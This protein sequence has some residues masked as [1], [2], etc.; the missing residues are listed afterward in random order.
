MRGH[1]RLSR[2]VRHLLSC[3]L[4][5]CFFRATIAQTTLS[6]SFEVASVRP[7]PPQADPNTGSWSFPDIS[8]FTATHV[9][10]ALLIQ[11]AYDVE[12]VQVENKPSWLE[13]NLYDV[14]AK[15]EA[16]VKLSR[17][18]LRPRLQNLLHERFHLVVHRETRSV[19]G[20]ALVVAKGGPYLTPTKGDHFPGWRINVSS[21]QMRGVNWSMAQLAKNLTSA[22]GF[23][24]VD[25]TGIAGSYDIG[26]SYNAKPDDDSNLPPLNIAL[27]Q[28][29]GL[30]LKQQKVPI[31]SI[32]ID[33]ADKTPTAN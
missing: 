26:F 8:Q 9:S 17:E 16:G 31:E 11:L 4:L 24:V 19:P 20:Y 1:L 27:E 25:H 29:T 10:L 12:N 21:G 7:A 18:E 33:S 3:G 5:L 30:Q 6:S 15:P 28:A 23:P 13:A 2:P 32:V 14:S 22:A